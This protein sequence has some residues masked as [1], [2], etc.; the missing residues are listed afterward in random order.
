MTGSPWEPVFVLSLATTRYPKIG[1]MRFITTF[2]LLLA[3]SAVYAQQ[4]IEDLE[5]RLLAATATADRIRLNY[6]LGE[7]YLRSNVRDNEKK[8]LP[9]AKEAFNLAVRNRD[10]GQAARSAFLTAQVYNGMRGQERNQ[11]VWYK[12]AED[13]ARKAGDSDLIVKSVIKRGKLARDET[14]LSPGNRYL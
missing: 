2:C 5:A 13:Y 10:D 14:K 7:A 6:Q 3:V 12:S 4:S 8:A 9:Y 11:E 1:A